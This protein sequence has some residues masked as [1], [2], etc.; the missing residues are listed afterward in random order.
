MAQNRRKDLAIQHWGNCVKALL[1][2]AVLSGLGILYVRQ[3]R[4]HEELGR[5]IAQHEK[6]REDL[7]QILARQR[8]TLVQLTSDSKLRERAETYKLGLAQT[9]PSQRLTIYVPNSGEVPS[10]A[11]YRPPSSSRPSASALA[12]VPVIPMAR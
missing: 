2:T 9:H 7:I 4:S 12:N 1:A 3:T 10:R 8:A 11:P 6:H 5:Q